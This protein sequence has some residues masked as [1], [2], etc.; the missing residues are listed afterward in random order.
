MDNKRAVEA[1]DDE[2]LTKLVPLRQAAATIGAQVQWDNSKQ[3]ATVTYG[4]RVWTIVLN[5]TESSVNGEQLVL[6]KPAQL[7]KK[8]NGELTVPWNA[9]QQALG[10]SGQW[11]DGAYIA[12]T[13]DWSAR[14]T[15]FLGQWIKAGKQPQG[16]ELAKLHEYMTPELKQVV[17]AQTLT[18]EGMSFQYF[19]TPEKIVS[20]KVSN[21]GVHHTVSA[22]YLTDKKMPLYFDVKLSSNGLVNDYIGLPMTS[23]GYKAPAYDDASAYKEESIV[24]GEGQFKLPGTLTLP[25]TKVEGGYP[26]VVLVH[27]SGMHDQDS[28]IGANKPFRDLAVGLAKQGV[29]SIRYNKRNLE[30]PHQIAGIPKLTV[31]QES[32][33]D[34]LLAV[35][36]A[37]QDKRLNSKRVFVLGHSQGGMIM[38]R[39]IE[40]DKDK[41]IAGAI[42]AAAPSGALEDIALRQFEDHLARSKS[43]GRPAEVIARQ[44]MMV[45]SAKKLIAILD[46]K[47]YSADNYPA[48]FPLPPASWWFDI[49]NNDGPERAKNQQVPLFIF[50]GENDFQVDLKQYE[51]WK[52]GLASRKDVTFK[53]YPKLNHVFASY[54]KP[55]TTDEYMLPGNVPLQLSE[56]I[57]AWIKV[58][59]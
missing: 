52:K 33:D 38:P 37:Q 27:G 48:D 46:D 15:Q 42:L 20:V 23:Q 3:T 59:K 41:A 44:E 17:T 55:S 24:V 50:N 40:Q 14:A 32:I 11:V 8:H 53:Q 45:A 19:G 4:E 16:A 25:T 30:Y 35:A 39:I 29:A 22:V 1:R 57:G 54:D 34:A 51:G 49:A 6:A 43:E 9:I 36:G 56:D 58:Q 12:G 21:N 26:V 18:G 31:K 28:T 13:N 7:S 5:K 47:Q 2:V 10:V